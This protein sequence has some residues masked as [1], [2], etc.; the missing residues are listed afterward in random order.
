MPANRSGRGDRVPSAASRLTPN[1]VPQIK[2]YRDLADRVEQVPG[3]WFVDSL[4]Q[5]L[6]LL[7]LLFALPA[8]RHLERRHPFGFAA[9]LLTVALVGRLYPSAYGWW[10]TTDV[11]GTQVVAWLF[12]LG[13]MAHRAT[14][15]AQRWTTVAAILVLVPTFFGAADALRSVIVVGGLLVLQFLPTVR[16]PRAVGRVAT[17][18]ASASLGIYLTHFGVL[19]L[20]WLGV[21]PVVIVAVSI[22]VGTGSWWAVTTVQ[23]YLATRM[24]AGSTPAARTAASGAGQAFATAAPR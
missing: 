19:P 11:Y 10:F 24:A 5:I 16:V 14:G 18:V 3:Y 13:W 15:K 2:S 9:G 23:R 12:V 20:S 8:L 1:K 7:A 17:T 6:L 22:G 4:V 21:P